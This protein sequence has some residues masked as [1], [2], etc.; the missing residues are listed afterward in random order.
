MIAAATRDHQRYRL[1]I[2][3]QLEG[4]TGVVR[5]CTK[6]IQANSPA[7]FAPPVMSPIRIW[8]APEGKPPER[9]SMSTPSRYTR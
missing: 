6:S 9:V 8:L 2:R 3:P 4:V 5:S 1:L 7:A